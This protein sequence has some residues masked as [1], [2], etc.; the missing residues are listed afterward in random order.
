M[1][2]IAVF[3]S[4]NGAELQCAI[5]ACADHVVRGTVDFVVYLRSDGSGLKRAVE[6]DSYSEAQAVSGAPDREKFF[7]QL[8]EEMQERGIDWIVM[9]EAGEELP[10]FFVEAFYPR[11]IRLAPSSHEV[12]IGAAGAMSVRQVLDQ[13]IAQVG[14]TA[15]LVAPAGH[16]LVVIETEHVPVFPDDTIFRLLQRVRK[17]G[18][19]LL[20]RVLS[21]CCEDRL[22]M[23][24]ENARVV[25]DPPREERFYF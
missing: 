16:P 12:P 17:A 15:Y 25:I 19:Y 14:C 2:K 4:E 7:H 3:L 1:K 9:L 23:D 22:H 8:Q 10:A 18:R 13:G 21:A 20:P 24:E 5:D 6:S 11:I